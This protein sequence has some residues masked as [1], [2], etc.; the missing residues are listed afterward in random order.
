M[1][2]RCVSGDIIIF[3]IF[4]YSRYTYRLKKFQVT[5]A[6]EI[7][8]VCKPAVHKDFKYIIYMYII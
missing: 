4:V 7:L 2:I 5:W 3:K 1:H 8:P 6:N